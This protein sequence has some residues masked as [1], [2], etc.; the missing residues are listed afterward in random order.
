[1]PYIVVVL[2]DDRFAIL[3]SYLEERRIWLEGP[4]KGGPLLPQVG[5]ARRLLIM[6]ATVMAR[7][8]VQVCQAT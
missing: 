1:M 7:L 4:A 2:L 6:M 8:Q 5:R 3:E